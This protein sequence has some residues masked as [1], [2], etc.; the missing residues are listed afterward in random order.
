MK[1][2]SSTKSRLT[3]WFVGALALILMLFTFTAYFLFVRAVRD[4]TDST[5]LEIAD[6]FENS[7]NEELRHENADDEGKTV[8]EA[9][10]DSIAEVSFKNYKI[11][12]FSSEKQLLTPAAK[13]LFQL[14]SNDVSQN[15]LADFQDTSQNQLRT[16]EQNGSKFRVL[17]RPITLGAKVFYILVIH[18]L[19]DHENLL[20]KVRYAFLIFVPLTVFLASFGG[21]LLVRK[22][23]APINEMRQKAEEITARNLYERL[24]VEIEEDELGRLANAFN[25]LLE[26][27]N[28][29]F[30]QQQRFMADASHELRTPVAI[31]RGESDVSLSR[32]DRTPSEYR[33]TVEII[34]TEAE[35]MSTII[36]DLFTLARADAG[37]NPVRKSNV[38]LEDILTDT[39]KAFRTIAAKNG[40]EIFVAVSLEMPFD[41]DQQLIQRLFANILDNAVKHAKSVVKI[42]AEISNNSYKIRFADDGEGIPLESQD[43]IFERFYRADRTRSRQKASLTGGGAGLGLSISKWITETHDGTIEIIRSGDDGTTIDLTFPTRR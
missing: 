11:A 30:D 7:T 22:S 1:I 18:S 16:F 34:Q 14:V 35:R 23:L 41:A 38:Y 3:A 21:Y 5:I 26:R 19:E 15:W 24:P 8:E 13:E 33:E 32:N 10:R 17:Y 43:H 4:Q 37:E 31:I 25:K 36:E 40:V 29:S 39:C 12:V 42:S 2:F 20:S 28:L 6:A 27:L 9:I